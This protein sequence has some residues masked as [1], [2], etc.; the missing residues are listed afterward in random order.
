MQPANRQIIIILNGVGSSGKSATARALQEITSIPLLHFSMDSFLE[1]LPER[2]FNHSD[3]LTFKASLADENPVISV[4][5]G[6]VC[7]KLLSG[8]RHAVAA[9][10]RQGN[11][12]IVDAERVNN[13]ETVGFWV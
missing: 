1:M 5:V 4:E 12:L 7:R 13:F 9:M 11:S 10:A 8:M 2:L 6:H 3:G